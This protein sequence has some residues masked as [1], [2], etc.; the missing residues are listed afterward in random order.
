MTLDEYLNFGRPIDPDLARRLV[1][2]RRIGE[3]LDEANKHAQ[4]PPRGRGN[5]ASEGAQES[6]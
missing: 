5:P 1:L 4:S 2:I 6:D 3:A